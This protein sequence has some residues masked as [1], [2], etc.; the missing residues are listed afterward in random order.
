MSANAHAIV[1]AGSQE[2]LDKARELGAI[3]AI[4]YRE[5]D[6]VEQVLQA[7]HNHGA[8]VI[9]DCVGGSFFE[10]N[11]RSAAQDARW[12]LYGLLGGD[13]IQGHVLSQ[14]LRKR[15]RLVFL[16]LSY[17]FLFLLPLPH[18]FFSTIVLLISC[19]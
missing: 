7:T 11:I 15:I 3:A 16:L 2:K 17:S 12:I 4:N 19:L 8:D 14:L 10:K 9:L 13:E 6:F 1:T 5:E 18:F